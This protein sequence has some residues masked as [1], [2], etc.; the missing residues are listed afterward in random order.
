MAKHGSL[1]ISH[2]T[3]YILIRPPSPERHQ[4][5]SSLRYTT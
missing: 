4:L 2:D 1:H 5:L 3:Q